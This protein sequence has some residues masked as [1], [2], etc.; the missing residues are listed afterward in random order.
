MV[1]SLF[2]NLAIFMFGACMS[3]F[4]SCVG[5]RIP[6]RMNWISG[7]SK[8]NVC[9][10][11]LTFWELIPVFSC[12]V[13]NARCSKCKA[14]FGWRNCMCE[15]LSGCAC[16][17]LTLFARNIPSRLTYIGMVSIF[18]IVLSA[19]QEIVIYFVTKK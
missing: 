3:S 10:K 8:C 14:Y 16:V 19:L 12:L 5:Y 7:H 13:L 11:P 1:N 18:C 2:A 17:V 9:G 6:R 4:G 15:A